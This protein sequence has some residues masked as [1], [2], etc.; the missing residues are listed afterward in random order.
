[1]ANK[2]YPEGYWS[3]VF[4]QAVSLMN[5]GLASTADAAYW[6]ARRNIDEAL[7]G[8]SPD[9]QP[10]AALR[11]RPIVIQEELALAS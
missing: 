10:P 2:R 5:M 6:T 9:P 8:S 7:H 11:L 4:E 1:M 3:A